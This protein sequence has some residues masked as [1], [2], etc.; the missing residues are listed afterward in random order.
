[1]SLRRVCSSSSGQIGYRLLA[2]A[3]IQAPELSLKRRTSRFSDRISWS[4]GESPLNVAPRALV[5]LRVR[6]DDPH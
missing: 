4:Y 2:N 6:P 1:M 3:P 5:R